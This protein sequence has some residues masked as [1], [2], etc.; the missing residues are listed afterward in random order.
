MEN[1]TV[2][3]SNFGTKLNRLLPACSP[4]SDSAA[5][6]GLIERDSLGGVQRSYVFFVLNVKG[7][8]DIFGFNSEDRDIEQPAMLKWHRSVDRRPLVAVGGQLL[9]CDSDSEFAASRLILVDEGEPIERGTPGQ[10]ND[11][12]RVALAQRRA[13]RVVV[14][15]E[16]FSVDLPLGDSRSVFSAIRSCTGM[17]GRKCHK[18][19][20]R[21]REG[22][23]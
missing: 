21:Q 15:H 5:A 7:E 11:K 13:D 14:H 8:P 20:N 3:F 19:T 23:R 4:R 2:V 12:G 17:S 10:E 9:V 18:N 22:D 16:K 6:D 1:M